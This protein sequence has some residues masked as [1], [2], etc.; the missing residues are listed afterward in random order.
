MLSP[1][2]SDGGLVR[3]AVVDDHPTSRAGLRVALGPGAGIRVVG[4]ADRVAAALPVVADTSPDVV[5]MDLHLPDGSGVRATEALLAV[6][7]GLAV[8]VMTMSEEDDAIVA[9]LR[10]G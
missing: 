3:V 7:P 4:E 1:V 9:A 8:L 10:A 2:M 5:V 6:H